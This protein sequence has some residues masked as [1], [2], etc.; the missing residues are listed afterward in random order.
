[1][2]CIKLTRSASVRLPGQVLA[3]NGS[4]LIA[5][6]LPISPLFHSSTG[7]QNTGPEIY[8]CGGIFG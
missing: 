1:M 6:A 3:G 5:F 8:Q 7:T 2:V 4:I